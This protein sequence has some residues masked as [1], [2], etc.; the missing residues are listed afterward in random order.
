[1][2]QSIQFDLALLTMNATAMTPKENVR[3]QDSTAAGQDRDG[4]L[5]YVN[6]GAS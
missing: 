2:Y 6:R 3:V 1:M 4:I 5:K